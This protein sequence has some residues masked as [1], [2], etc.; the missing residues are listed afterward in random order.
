MEI[1]QVDPVGKLM[2]DVYFGD[3]KDNPPILTRLDRVEQAIE[4]MTT[5]S[6]Q[7]KW[8]LYVAAAAM[9][10]NIISSHVKF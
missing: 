6:N 9:I 2:T 8:A 5:N 1:Q 7:M 4:A 10:L 3:G